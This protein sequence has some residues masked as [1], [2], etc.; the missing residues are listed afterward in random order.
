MNLA[1]PDKVTTRDAPGKPHVV[2]EPAGGPCPPT[3]RD[4]FCDDCGQPLGT[5]IAPRG[6][7]RRPAPDNK[8]INHFV[9]RDE[10]LKPQRP[11][12]FFRLRIVD[13]LTAENHRRATALYITARAFRFGFATFK[14]LKSWSNFA[15]QHLSISIRVINGRI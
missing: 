11:R 5:G 15:V 10:Q 1:A 12:E 4:I 6:H 9:V 8:N 13:H 2:F 14:S 7:T 3:D